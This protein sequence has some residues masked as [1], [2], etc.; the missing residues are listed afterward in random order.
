MKKFRKQ[1][2]NLIHKKQMEKNK[3]IMQK[4]NY[5]VEKMK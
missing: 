3:L 4:K 2:V 1:K 5:K